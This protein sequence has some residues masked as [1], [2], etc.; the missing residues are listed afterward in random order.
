MMRPL[1]PAPLAGLLALLLAGPLQAQAPERAPPAPPGRDATKVEVQLPGDALEVPASDLVRAGAQAVGGMLAVDPQIE[2]IRL[3]LTVSTPG[4]PVILTWGAI[5]ALLDFHDIVVV[6]SRPTPDSPFII[7]VHHRRNINQK[8]GPPWRVVDGKALPDWDELVTVLFRVQHGAGNS[9]FA[10]VRGLL[11]RDTNRIGNILY[12]Q[13]SEIII[14]VDLASKVRYY[15]EV[16]AGLDVPSPPAGVGHTF[17]LR[18]ADPNVVASALQ[19]LLAPQT[20]ASGETVTVTASQLSAPALR[21]VAD[22]RTGQVVITGNPAAIEEAQR[23]V[24]ALD[25]ADVARDVVLRVY[26]V[27]VED[28]R[29]VRA[30]VERALSSMA[31]FTATQRPDVFEGPTPKTLAVVARAADL[32]RVEE[33]IKAA[34]GK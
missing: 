2:P 4:G 11:T 6:E 23:I 3:K 31:S 28:V 34:T 16:I 5:K 12:V 33:A 15:A 14:I 21:V 22:S 32:P 8:E 19:R 24:A 20:V 17:K 10:T 13:G 9:I 1:S 26:P 25:V 30:F 7:R 18:S 29:A 27:E